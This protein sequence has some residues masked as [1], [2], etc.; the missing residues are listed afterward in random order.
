MR[1]GSVTSDR[2]VLVD[3]QMDKKLGIGLVCLGLLGAAAYLVRSGDALLTLVPLSAMAGAL[4]YLRMTLL[5][6][7]I[8]F[9]RPGDCVRLTVSGRKEAQQWTWPLSQVRTA[10][11][12]S[13]VRGSG[14]DAD[15]RDRPVLILQDGTEVP[16]RPY[17]SAGSQSWQAVEAI[18][19]F[20]GDPRRDDFPVGYIF[21]P[22]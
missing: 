9:D 19:K 10:A 13:I 5:S 15:T 17:H 16:L 2:L 6:T 21:D 14:G 1:T 22:D 3:T 11:I 7:E 20:L 12:G 8:V 4:L 18:R